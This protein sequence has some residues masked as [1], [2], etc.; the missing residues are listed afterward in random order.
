M[1]HFVV[2]YF[3]LMGPLYLN[4]KYSNQQGHMD[5]MKEA[6]I[7]FCYNINKLYWTGFVTLGP[8]TPEHMYMLIF[9]AQSRVSQHILLILKMSNHIL[10]YLRV[11]ER[12]FIKLLCPC[13]ISCSESI[14]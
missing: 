14:L 5:F 13:L 11:F 10:A 3:A 4:W 8:C 9:R 6:F 1:A 12:V 7:I 2:P